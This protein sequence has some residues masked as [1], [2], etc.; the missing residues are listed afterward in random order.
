MVYASSSTGC[1]LC[2]GTSG[3]GSAIGPNI[4]G[5]KAAGIGDWTLAQFTAA[6]RM[7]KD[8]DGSMLCGTMVPQPAV[9]EQDAADMYAFLL[10]K[11]NDTPM[12]GACP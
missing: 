8:K 4:S 6:V 10:S 2:H 3:E 7:G 12:K 1:N 9:T 5:S 11:T